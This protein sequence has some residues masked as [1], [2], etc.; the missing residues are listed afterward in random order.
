MPAIL[1]LIIASSSNFTNGARHI[2]PVYGFCIVLAAA[3]AIWIARKSNFI[4]YALV[5]L[6][7]FHAVAAVRTA[8]NYLA[9]ANDFWGGYENTYRIFRGANLDIGQSTKLMNEYLER[10]G[11][12]D[13]WFAGYVHP[14][15]VGAIQPCRPMP[16]WLRILISRNLIDAVPPVIEGTVLIN[17]SEVALGG[18]EYEPLTRSEP[19]AVIGG[20][21]FVYRGRFE[22]PL[23][24]AIS[25]VHRSGHFLR[26]N[27]PDEAVEEGRRAIALGPSDPRTHLALGLALARL[28]QKEE[29]QLELE[30]T[31]Q[32]AKADPRFRNHEVRAQL[33]LERLK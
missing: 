9:F 19:V 10:E 2:L 17:I 13:C 8:P 20:S 6:L 11:I 12:T 26:N 14:E 1:F 3:G 29:A 18:D 25:H 16:S 22:V 32:H 28:G 27:L 23:A 21:I 5:A 33:E 4:R 7:V 30:T 31:V 24:A 15:L